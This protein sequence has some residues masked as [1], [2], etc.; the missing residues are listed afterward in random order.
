MTNGLGFLPYSNSPH[1]DSEE[2]RRPTIHRLI[3][4]GTLP[5]GY[6][7]DDGTGLVFEGTDLVAPG[8]VR[9]EEWQPDDETSDVGRSFLWCG[10]GR[11]R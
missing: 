6:A 4:E 8:L 1:H 11:K 7:S 10:V 5:E 3:G 9:V 2:Q